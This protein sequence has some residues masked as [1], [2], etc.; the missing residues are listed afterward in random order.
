MKDD[1]QLTLE[2][3]GFELQGSTYMRIFS[4]NTQYSTRLSTLVETVIKKL[5][6]NKSPGPDGFTGKF[7]QTLREQLTPILLKLFPKIAGEETHNLNRPITSSE[8]EFVLKKKNSQKIKLQGQM[9][10]QGN[11]NKHIKKN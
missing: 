8:N 6:T 5:P 9:A 1:I 7:S 2:R 11:S 3:H 10:S 4:I